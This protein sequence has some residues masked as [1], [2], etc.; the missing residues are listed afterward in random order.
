MSMKTPTSTAVVA[1]K[2]IQLLPPDA[3]PFC[4]CWWETTTT[5]GASDLFEQVCG[6]YRS[7]LA[8]TENRTNT[9]VVVGC[10]CSTSPAK[11]EIA[12]RLLLRLLLRGLPYGADWISDGSKVTSTVS[13]ALARTRSSFA[14]RC[15]GFS[16]FCSWLVPQVWLAG[17]PHCIQQRF[18]RMHCVNINTTKGQRLVASVVFAASKHVLYV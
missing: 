8:A 10:W 7:S 5:P 16:Y 2:R 4:W 3:N 13:F 12:G 14:E 1:K 6:A 17:T 11:L 18:L 15:C 9:I